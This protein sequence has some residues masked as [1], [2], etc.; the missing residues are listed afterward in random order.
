MLVAKF[1]TGTLAG[2][3]NNGVVRMLIMAQV[4]KKM[5]V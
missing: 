1:L 3:R 5:Y 2:L 4:K